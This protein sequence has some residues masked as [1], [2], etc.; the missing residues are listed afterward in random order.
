MFSKRQLN[1]S[2][3][4][5]INMEGIEHKTITANGLNIH[6]AQKGEGPIVLFI[7]GFPEL[8]YSWRHQILFLADHGYRAVAPDLRGYGDT[9]GAPLNDPTKFTIHHLVGD[10]IGVLDA[11]TKDGEKVFVVGHDWG[12]IIAWHLCLFRPDRVM[13]LVNMSVPFLPW[14]PNG[15]MA[16][17]LKNAYGEDHYMSR[18]QEPGDIEAELGKMSAETVMKKFLAYRDP[19]QIYFPKGKGFRYSPGDTPVTLPSWLSEE[20][21]QYFASSLQKTGITG[22]VNYYRA[23]RLS[24][25]LTAAWKGAKVMVPTKFIIGDLDLTY[26]MPG[27]KDYIVGDEFKKDVPLLEEVVVMEGVAH[28]VN[29]EKPDQVNKHLIDFLQKF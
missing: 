23:F 3:E 17:M 7:H 2:E 21:V 19:D 27:L 25:E 22:A 18:F 24:W 9:T 13:G 14:N 28:F 8:W 5:K 1:L 16:T 29:Q 12:A 15:D 20:D 10:M 26:H 6:I 11:I 4:T